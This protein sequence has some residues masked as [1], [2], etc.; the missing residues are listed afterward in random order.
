MGQQDD[1][2]QLLTDV[3]N[4]SEKLNEGEQ[5]FIES[6]YEHFTENGSL[7]PQQYHKLSEIWERVT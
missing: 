7:F 2:E 6:I 3:M 5:N 1:A 4:R